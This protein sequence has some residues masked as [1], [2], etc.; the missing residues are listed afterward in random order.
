MKDSQLQNE[1][2]Y[3]H[4][5]TVK[6]QDVTV[7]FQ[8][9][10]QE[11]VKVKVCGRQTGTLRVHLARGRLQSTGNGWPSQGLPLWHLTQLPCARDCEPRVYRSYK[12]TQVSVGSLLILKYCKTLY[13]T[14]TISSGKM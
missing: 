11:A 14:N 1:V 9:L 7:L 4:E 6:T 13:G 3:S 5:D 10:V 2:V 12:K 8:S